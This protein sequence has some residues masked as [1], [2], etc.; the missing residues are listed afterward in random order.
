M[1]NYF[2]KILILSPHVDDGFIGCGGTITKFLENGAEVFYAVFSFS[3]I[4]IPKELPRGVNREDM[5]RAIEAAGIEKENLILLA[6][7]FAEETGDGDGITRNFPSYRQKILEMMVN[8]RKKHQFDL[9]LLPCSFDVHQDHQ[10]VFQEGFRAFK[11]NNLLGYELP[12]N[13][14]IFSPGVF[15]GLEKSHIDKKN[16]CLECFNSQKNKPYMSSEFIKNLA[17][18]AS[19]QFG[20][21]K[22]VQ[23]A[24]SFEAVRLFF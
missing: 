21:H 10:T 8:L 23:Y 20:E 13:N 9:V 15:V 11:K 16:N 6:D 2:K 14:R 7:N 19:I 4:S 22:D 3:G 18:A 24:E 5:L 1:F 17:N 12:W